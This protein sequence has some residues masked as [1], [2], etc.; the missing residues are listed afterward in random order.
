MGRSQGLEWGEG[1]SHM[2]W[3]CE[4]VNNSSSLTLF[5]PQFCHL[6]NDSNVFTRCPLRS[7]QASCVIWAQNPPTHTHT[8]GLGEVEK[9]WKD[10]VLDICYVPFLYSLLPLWVVVRDFFLL[11]I[12]PSSTSSPWILCETELSV[13]GVEDVTQAWPIKAS[14][15]SS[16]N[17]RRERHTTWSNPARMNVRTSTEASL[18]QWTEVWKTVSLVGVA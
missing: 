1:C 18:S 11:Q 16:L 3:Q 14:Q 12:H 9:E 4:C 8:A 10:Q 7:T 15:S 2:Q 13:P 5:C 17:A 6:W